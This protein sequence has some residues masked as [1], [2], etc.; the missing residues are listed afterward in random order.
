MRV[1]LNAAFIGDAAVGIARYIGCLTT[2]LCKTCEVTV[3][4]SRPEFFSGLHCSIIP[5]P[6]WTSD[7]RKRPLW[8]LFRLSSLLKNCQ[9]PLICPTPE[10]P[11]RISQPVIAVV[12][13]LIP[14]TLPKLHSPGVKALCWTGL[15]TLRWADLIVTD[16]ECTRRDLIKFKIAASGRTLVIPAGPGILPTDPRPERSPGVL[17]NFILYVGG[18]SVHKNVPRLIAAF[19]RLNIPR[20]VKLVIV[21]WGTEKDV[22]RTRRAVESCQLTDRVELLPRVSD[23]E[24]SDLYRNCLLFVFPSLYEGFGL[25]VLEALKH[26]AP[27]V[28][29]KAASLPEVAGS[30][31]VYF[32]PFSVDDIAQSIASVLSQPTKLAMLRADGPVRAEK[33]SWGKT[34]ALLIDAIASIRRSRRNERSS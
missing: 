10:V 25:P 9:A 20:K 26:G 34:A 8:T 29:S 4:T 32:N 5:L 33:F 16:S 1:V 11:P 18:H 31:A 13:D 15:Q 27:V 24:L 23:S 14:L 21:G 22:A 19:A 7:Q 28:C 2:E 17:G 6:R 3:L 12:H 30:A